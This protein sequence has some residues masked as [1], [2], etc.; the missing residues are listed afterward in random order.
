MPLDLLEAEI[1]YV[2]KSII[3]VKLNESSWNYL[4]G[5]WNL[6]KEYESIPSKIMS[7]YVFNTVVLR[8]LAFIEYFVD[9]KTFCQTILIEATPICTPCLHP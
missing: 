8:L 7:M 2:K 1:V 4:R 3:K 9:A 5:I 6:H